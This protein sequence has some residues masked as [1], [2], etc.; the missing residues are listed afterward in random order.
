M[1]LAYAYNVTPDFY[2]YSCLTELADGSIGLLYESASSKI[3]F[4]TYE[5]DKI[6]NRDNDPRLSIRE[7]ELHEGYSEVITDN[8]GYYVDADISEL[9]TSVATLT[10]TGEQVTTN[11][12]QVLGSGANI[13]LDSCQYTFTANDDGTFTVSAKRNV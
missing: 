12:A 13:D 11:A 10:M 7:I 5:F 6:A 1:E 4:V 3:D 8:S 9:D 2:A